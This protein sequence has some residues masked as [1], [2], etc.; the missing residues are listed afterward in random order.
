M[1][2]EP[3]ISPSQAPASMLCVLRRASSYT[4]AL[5]YI[6]RS[7]LH[8]LQHHPQAVRMHCMYMLGAERSRRKRTCTWDFA[9]PIRWAINQETSY[10]VFPLRGQPVLYAVAR[11]KHD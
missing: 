10:L 6:L 3:S 9:Q 2:R 7:I 11:E 8:I 5:I 1:R 4:D